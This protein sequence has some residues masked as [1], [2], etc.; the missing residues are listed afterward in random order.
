MHWGSVDSCLQRTPFS[1]PKVPR[2]LIFSSEGQ[3]SIPNHL[4][5]IALNLPSSVIFPVVQK[6]EL[7]RVSRFRLMNVNY[8][9]IILSSFSSLCSCSSRPGCCWPLC[10]QDTQLAH[11]Q[12]AIHQEPQALFH[13]DAARLSVPSLCYWWELA[14]TRSRIYCLYLLNIIKSSSGPSS[15]LWQP[16][17]QVSHSEMKCHLQTWCMSHL[18]KVTANDDQE[19]LKNGFS[20]YSSDNNYFFLSHTIILL[21]TSLLS[22]EWVNEKSV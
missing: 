20:Y 11:D 9:A 21:W 4:S 5:S 8:W 22:T 18:F 7:S 14:C 16:C 1:R 3:C 10:C 13:R 15:N 12:L 17:L 2:S 19:K 6:P